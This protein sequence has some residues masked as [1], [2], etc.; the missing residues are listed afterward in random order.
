MNANRSPAAGRPAGVKVHDCAI[1]L[2]PDPGRVVLRFFLPGSEAVGPGAS[3]AGPVLER[4][5]ALSEADV[6]ATMGDIDARF[7]H[8][9]RTIHETFRHHA[10]L[11]MSRVD[12]SIALSP[13]RQLLLGATFSHEYS[14][15]GAALCNPSLVL[16]PVQDDEASVRFVMSLRAIG[17][18]H[19]ST[20]GFRC[21]R[22]GHDGTVTIEAAGAFPQ[23]GPSTPGL[24]HRSVLH[25]K[26]LELGDDA[27]NGA[28]I[29]DSLPER[30][31]DDELQAGLG[32][33]AADDL[34]RSN[35]GRTIANLLDLSRTSYDV[36]FPK[37][38]AISERVLWP[39]MPIESQGME[40][41]RFVRF[42]DE[43]GS[44]CY[45]GTYTAFDGTNISQQLIQS[46]DFRSFSMSPMAGDAAVGKGLALFPRKI[47]GRYVALSRSDRETNAVAFSD[48]LR[49]WRDAVVVQRPTRSWEILQ[50]GNCGSP[51]ETER[52]WLVLTHGVGPMRTYAVGAMLLDL[53]E[54]QRVLATSEQPILK[55]DATH[56]DGYVPNVVYTCG[57]LA[58]GD[59]LVVPYGVGDQRIEIATLSISELLDSLTR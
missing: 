37:E 29:L 7:G 55:P 42:T 9:H 14:I 36:E 11:V 8:R 22:V 28:F 46:V 18:G 38:T 44:V 1:T 5:L 35:T 52:G 40:D 10:A 56:R 53:D 20:I 33:L 25:A 51:I 17:E 16:H 27:E 59:T 32:R 31:D 41:A 45:Y 4:L 57:A 6:V 21:G 24:H 48:D 15:E 34:T 2:S 39:Q 30:F 13:S 23:T 43:D 12:P 19:L 58:H 47:G 3:R 26:L 54:P 50:L 49:W